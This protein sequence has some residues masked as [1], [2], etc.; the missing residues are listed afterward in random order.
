[1]IL[2]KKRND[3]NCAIISVSIVGFFY[4]SIIC[5]IQVDIKIFCVPSF[6][7]ERFPDLQIARLFVA[8]DSLETA[9]DP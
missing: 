8:R 3:Y 6:A 2:L 9:D 4:V 1:M 5:S 7:N